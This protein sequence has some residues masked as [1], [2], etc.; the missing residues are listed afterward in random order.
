MKIPYAIPAFGGNEGKYI[1]NALKSTWISGGEYVN[2]LEEW[3]TK[4]LQRKHALAVSNGTAA[5]H[6]VY[7]GLG[8]KTGN[9][10][11]VPGFAFMAAANVLVNINAIPIF[12]DVDSDTWCITAESIESKI[13]KKTKA[14]VPIHTYGNVCDMDKIMELAT[15]NSIPVI[16]DGAEALFSTYKGKYCGT[17]AELGIFS[18]HATKTITTGEGGLVICDDD[19]LAELMLM[20]RNH[21]LPKRGCYNHV[22]AGL[23]FRLSNIQA[24]LGC[25]QVENVENIIAGRQRVFEVYKNHLEKQDGIRLQYYKP[26]VEPVVWAVAVKLDDRAFPQGR[27]SVVTQLKELGIETRPGFVAS[28]LL[29]YFP[30]HHLPISES[31]SNSVIS[32]PTYPSLS[33]DDISLICESL[34]HEKK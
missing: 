29:G 30:P 4:T 15:S 18:M 3:F 9:E 16:E 28:S 14:I 5:L 26:E 32:L 21:G 25:A 12:A 20:Y 10:V 2:K 11:I 33:N 1:I 19:K 23:N 24:A 7:L 17:F 27:D 22:V 8:I 6:L 34:I 31:L 13:T